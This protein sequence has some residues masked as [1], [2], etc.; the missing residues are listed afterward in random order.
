ME[1]TDFPTPRLAARILR[2]DK[3]GEKTEM[4]AK[5]EALRTEDIQKGVFVPVSHLPK[6][7]PTRAALPVAVNQ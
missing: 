7:K 6:S 4:D 5:K 2:T 3:D 1:T